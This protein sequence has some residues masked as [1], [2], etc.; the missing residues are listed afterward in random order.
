MVLESRATERLGPRLKKETAA[1][2]RRIEEGLGLVDA[3][4]SVERY[5]R[6]LESFLGY[7][8]PVES[9]IAELASS[10]PPLGLELPART[11]L[12]VKD[13][14]ALGASASDI[15]AVPQCTDLPRLVEPANLAG[16][17]YVLEGSRLGGVIVARELERSLGLGSHG[18]AFFVGDG[19][20]VARRFKRVLSWLDEVAR[21][22]AAPDV[23]V[24]SACETFRTL[25]RWTEARGAWR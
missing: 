18:A 6:L 9:R 25:S 21:A 22:G 10:A 1:L 16:C 19:E 24:A 3:G 20:N 23:I 8:V 7:F 5:R 15:A 11:P 14:M 2:H 4:L 17:L 12:L 13:L